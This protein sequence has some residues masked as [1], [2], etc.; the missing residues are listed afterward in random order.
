MVLTKLVAL[1]YSH[2]M[3]NYYQQFTN[4]LLQ[5]NVKLTLFSYKDQQF[6]CLSR[7]AGVLLHN[8]PYL[9]QF[10]ASNPHINNKLACLV[11]ELLDLPYLKVVFAVFAAVGVHVIEPFYS[12]T[13]DKMSTHSTLKEF[14]TLLYNDLG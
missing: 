6:G 4:F 12:K 1:E 13:I 2:K 7:A 5:K 8:L 10:L 9:E 14:Y 3:W 11:R